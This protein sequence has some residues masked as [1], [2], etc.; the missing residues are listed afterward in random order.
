MAATQLEQAAIW[1]E[2]AFLPESIPALMQSE[3][4]EPTRA[5]FLVETPERSLDAS[6]KGTVPVDPLT[7]M[8][9]PILPTGSIPRLADG[10]HA[11]WHHHYH[12]SDDPL[13][14]SISGLAIRHLRLQLLPVKSRHQVYHNLFTGPEELPETSEQRFGHIVLACAGYVPRYAIDV[15][16]DDPAE[17]VTMAKKMHERL[18]TSGEIKVRGQ[19]NIANF[20]RRHLVL[21]NFSHVEDSI[22]E[23]FLT[24]S[25]INRKRYLGHWLLAIASEIATEPIKPIYRQALDEGLVSSNKKLPNIA[26]AALSGQKTQDKAIKDLHRRLTKQHQGSI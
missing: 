5:L 18:Q 1:N 25:S 7:R 15:R 10:R 16:K 4:E 8:P 13:L 21:Q 20:I 12:P 11:N 9:L 22:I 26:K 23:E 14:T 6:S 19:G 2:P 17:P 3:Q 24:T